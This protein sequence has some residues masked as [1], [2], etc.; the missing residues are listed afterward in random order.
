LSGKPKMPN[1]NI[2]RVA[3]ITPS[4]QPRFLFMI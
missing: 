2:S 4:F 1:R 3:T